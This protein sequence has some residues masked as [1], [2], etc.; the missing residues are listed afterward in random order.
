MLLLLFEVTPREGHV[1]EYLQTAAA[2]RPALDAQ[3]G[4]LFL[5]R[6][7]SLSR[8]RAL[9]SFQVWRDDVA[10]ARWRADPAH[11]QAQALGRTRVFEDYRLRVARVLRVESHDEAPWIVTPDAGRPG[12]AA[13]ARPVAL[14]ESLTPGLAGATENYES[15]YRP[16]EFAHVLEWPGGAPAPTLATLS[17]ARRLR[18]AAI[19]RDYGPRERAEAPQP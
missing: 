1:D 5:D 12:G 15:I 4:C 11:R 8:P 10:M 14:A 16:G 6:Y 18:I 2:L 3:G 17:G 7:R 13:A 19:E 9:L